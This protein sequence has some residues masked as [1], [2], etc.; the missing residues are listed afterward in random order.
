MPMPLY[1]FITQVEA[2]T[3]P[4]KTQLLHSEQLLPYILVDNEYH[5]VLRC[6]VHQW[7]VMSL[8]VQGVLWF[9]INCLNDA[10][11]SQYGI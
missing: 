5:S 9:G 8:T 3:H 4:S 7:R 11:R 2:P 10:R 1:N 6:L